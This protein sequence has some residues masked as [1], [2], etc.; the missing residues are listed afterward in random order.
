MPKT[1]SYPS[2]GSPASPFIG[3]KADTLDRPIYRF[4]PFHRLVQ[5]MT[6]RRLTLVRTDL[7]DDPWENY[8][9]HATFHLGRA[10]TQLNFRRTVYGSCWTRKSVSDALWRIYSPDKMAIRITSTPRLIGLALHAG[11]ARRARA[12]WFVGSVQYL[13]QSDIVRRAT[14]IAHDIATDRSGFAAARSVLFKRRSFAHEDEVRVL[15]IDPRGRGLGGMMH[16]G[17]DPHAVVTSVMLDSR[18]PKEV[19]DMYRAYL[20]RDLRYRGRVARSTLYDLPKGLEVDLS[21]R[22]K[23]PR[24]RND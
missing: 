11:L 18:T 4:I 9:S 8:I 2:I 17:L 23:G 12:S 24:T 3:F 10:A 1:S 16:V 20:T 13:A 15:I 14:D 6:T 22:Y 5:L 19:A 7:W 21:A